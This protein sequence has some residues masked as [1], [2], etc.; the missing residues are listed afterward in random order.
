MLLI[1]LCTMS[2]QELK[3]TEMSVPVPAEREVLIRVL[4]CGVCRTDVHIMDN[5]LTPPSFPVIPGHQIIGI[6]EQT[7]SEVTGLKR[8]DKVGVPW[9]GDTCRQCSYCLDDM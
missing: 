9:L 8:G 5:D 3:L 2:V 1:V 4:A 7:G 6:V